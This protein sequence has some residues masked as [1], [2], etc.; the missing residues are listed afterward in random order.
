MN[1]TFFARFENGWP[2]YAILRQALENVAGKHRRRLKAEAEASSGEDETDEINVDEGEGKG[3]GEEDDEEEE[4]EGEH[5][6]LNEVDDVER[7]RVPK[8]L[9]K[10]ARLSKNAKVSLRS[11]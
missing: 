4:G 8:A 10:A 1:H 6:Q 2:I 5:E 11:S 7:E 3:K 9:S